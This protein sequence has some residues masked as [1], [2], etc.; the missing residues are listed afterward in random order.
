MADGGRQGMAVGPAEYLWQRVPLLRT[1]GESQR[2]GEVFGEAVAG[3]QAEQ[4]VADRF[5]V[6][7]VGESAQFRNRD[8]G[9]CGSLQQSPGAMHGKTRSALRRRGRNPCL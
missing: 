5:E 9:S 8:R 1:R 3:S 7:N 2:A 6:P 4:R